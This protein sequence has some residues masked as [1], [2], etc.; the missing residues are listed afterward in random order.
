M[1]VKSGCETK[2]AVSEQDKTS[3]APD[4]RNLVPRERVVSQKGHIVT[5]GVGHI[6]HGRLVTPD[7][8]NLIPQIHINHAH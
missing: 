6:T 2:V 8:C 5:F 4:H 7:M 1:G 3:A